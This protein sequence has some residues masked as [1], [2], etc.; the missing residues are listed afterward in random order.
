MDS[1]TITIAPNDDSGNSTTLTVDTSGDQ[2]RITDVRLH[3]AAGLTGGQM[4]TVDFELLLRAVA[5]T[6]SPA[7]IEAARTTTPPIADA[8]PPATDVV[9]ETA[10]ADETPAAPAV[11]AKPRRAKRTAGATPQPAS[12]PT[13]ARARTAKSATAKATKSGSKRGRGSAVASAEKAAGKTAAATEPRARAYRRMPD[14]FAAVYEQISTPTAVA[15]HYGVPR[16]TVQGWIRRVK[17]TNT[18]KDS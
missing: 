7:P 9:D 1:Y 15:A 4:P 10:T 11:E 5:P 17:A 8:Q 13:A 16:H 6:G 18:A 2:V 12:R 3:A 14:D